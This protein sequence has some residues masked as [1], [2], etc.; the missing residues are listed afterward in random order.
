MYPV[1]SRC[2]TACQYLLLNKKLVFKLLKYIHTGLLSKYCHVRDILEWQFPITICMSTF[3]HYKLQSKH[4][5]KKLHT[6]KYISM[7]KTWE[8]WTNQFLLRVLTNNVMYRAWNLDHTL[9]DLPLTNW[10]GTSSQS[11]IS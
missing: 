10:H 11:G 6:L 4:F 7:Y 9:K 3:M 2:M 1:H 5:S 8:D